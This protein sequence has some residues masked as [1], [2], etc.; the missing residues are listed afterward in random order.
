MLNYY[1]LLKIGDNGNNYNDYILSTIRN[2]FNKDFRENFSKIHFN[3]T[4]RKQARES[5]ISNN[6]I[7]CDKETTGIYAS[8]TTLVFPN[9]FNFDSVSKGNDTNLWNNCGK[10]LLSNFH[11]SRPVSFHFKETIATARALHW[12]PGKN[13]DNNG[14]IYHIRFEYNDVFMVYDFNLVYSAFNMIA[15]KDIKSGGIETFLV[16][17][18]CGTTK[19]YAICGRSKHGIV[20]ILPNIIDQPTIYNV[21][22]D[23]YMDNEKSLDK[24]MIERATKT[25]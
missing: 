22:F 12:M 18:P 7:F 3:N 19:K 24:A 13:P 8:N 1:Q 5:F 9:G 21:D 23:F 16:L 6:K 15:D 10:D 2:D 25:A 14:H 11:N 4:T 20:F 17:F